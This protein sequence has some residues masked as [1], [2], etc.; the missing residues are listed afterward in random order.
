MRALSSS[1]A[2]RV[3]S[4]V[5]AVGLLGGCSL[6]NG[7]VK[8]SFSCRAPDGTC[9]PTSRIDD[10]AV[11][12]IAGDQSAS[13]AQP[14]RAGHLASSGGQGNARAVNVPQRR[15]GEKVLR[16]MFPAYIDD[17]GRLHEASAVHAVVADGD[18]VPD[19]KPVLPAQVSSEPAARAP[20]AL[21]AA[22]TVAPA[23]V[24]NRAPARIEA[25]LSAG[26][27]EVS[28]TRPPTTVEEVRAKV[29]AVLA[30]PHRAIEPVPPQAVPATNPSGGGEPGN[31][32]GAVRVTTPGLPG[33]PEED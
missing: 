19:G 28:Q 4:A 26:S 5:L 24:P 27:E 15:T 33:A 8:G 22:A 7:N 32:A 20:I 2:S 10:A 23:L 30:K 14:A 21:G 3:G 17:R 16:I 29:D 18:W 9:A 6:L 31:E 11:A 13:V 1:L 12:L 25:D